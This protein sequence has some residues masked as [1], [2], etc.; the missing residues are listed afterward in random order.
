MLRISNRDLARSLACLTSASRLRT[1]RVSSLSNRP[2]SL[3]ARDQHGQDNRN[4]IRR[5]YLCKGDRLLL[6]QCRL[7]RPPLSFDRASNVRIAE[8][9]SYP[10]RGG[11]GW[12][13]V[14]CPLIQPCTHTHPDEHETAKRQS[15]TRRFA[16]MSLSVSSSILLA[17]A[18]TTPRSK[19]R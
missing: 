16:G 14:V 10:E 6:V 19:R 2:Q 12:Q 3:T 8:C 13:A 11:A 15:Q 4:Q 17:W 18:C 9:S 5:P 7:T 1:N